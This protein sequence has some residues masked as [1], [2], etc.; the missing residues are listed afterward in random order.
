MALLTVT[1]HVYFRY[2][3]TNYRLFILG[4]LLTYGF[5]IEL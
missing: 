4:R 2:R 5:T 1:R 3:V